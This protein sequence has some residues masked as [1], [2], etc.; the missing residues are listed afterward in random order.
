[1]LTFE[2]TLSTSFPNGTTDLPNAVVVVGTGSNCVPTAEQDADCTTDTTVEAAPN[3][4]AVKTVDGEHVTT[5][6][7]GDVLH[8][9]I[10]VTNS[11]DAAG[12]ADV[13]DDVS[14]ILAHA[15]I[16]AI[17]DGG[18]LTA[19]VI[20]WPQFSL[21]ALTGTKTLTF[22]ATLSTSFPNGTTDLPNAVVVVGTGSNCVPTA[23]QDADCT[24]DTS[25]SEYKLT[26]DKTNDA[27]LVT[28]VLPDNTTADLPTADE[29]TT[30]TYTLTYAV[31]KLSV[32]N[33]V[34]TDVLPAGI[35]YVAGSATSNDEFTFESY[36]STTRTLSWT[37]AT[38]T[39][40]GSVTYKA[41]VLTGASALSQPLTNVATIDSAQTV[42]ASDT[43]DIFVPV[44]PKGETAPPTDI[45]VAP[46]GT[47]SPGSSLMLILVV[48]GLLVVSI[49]LITPVPAVVRRRNQ[50]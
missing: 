29:G 17:S 14:A 7:P 32:H 28:L 26:I 49:G 31:G 37:A 18:T 39:K 46:D 35:Q 42:P 36:D 48:L 30:V 3:I 10:T 34:I 16:G 8:Y 25:V 4:H 50:R 47:N 27:P 21:A 40:G 13:T 41:L 12:T 6:N 38:V 33:G 20:T 23:E 24:T 15:T 45:L 5:A 2:A 22:E 43:S 9:A 44:I 1:T 11:G 19:G